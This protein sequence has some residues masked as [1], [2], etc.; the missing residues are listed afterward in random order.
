MSMPASPRPWRVNGHSIEANDPDGLWLKNEKTGWGV[1]ANLPS[2]PKY[3]MSKK[4]RET[5]DAIVEANAALIVA[6]V[7]ERE[8][9]RDALRDMEADA[10]AAWEGT[11]LRRVLVKHVTALHEALAAALDHANEC[12]RR[13]DRDALVRERAAAQRRL[14][15][16]PDIEKRKSRT[17]ASNFDA[18]LAGF[19]SG[20]RV[21]L[22]RP[23][24]GAA[25]P[26][27]L[28]SC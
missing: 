22:S 21:A 28:A 23:V 6:A 19:R 4:N 10:E 17:I 15:G 12:S 2:C 1:V 25:A 27:R 18:Q 16:E 11:S 3:R 26:L 9:V 14:D 20:E 8:A 7:N 13:A 24:A 5:W